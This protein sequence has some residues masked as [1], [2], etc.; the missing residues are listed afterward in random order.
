MKKLLALVLSTVMISSL[1]ACGSAETAPTSAGSADGK[2]YTVGI[3]QLVQHP[4]LDA[5]S[6][7]FEAANRQKWKAGDSWI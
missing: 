6:E 2:T 7:G 1:V 4:A 5:A 3:C